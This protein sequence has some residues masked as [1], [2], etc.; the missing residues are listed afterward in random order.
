[1]EW[2][3][4]IFVGILILSLVIV[5]KSPSC[6]QTSMAPKKKKKPCEKKTNNEQF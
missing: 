1:M 4:H 5:S 3:A 2:V 6:E